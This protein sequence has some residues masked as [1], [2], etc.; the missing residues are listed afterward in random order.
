[1]RD[2]LDYIIGSLNTNTKDYNVMLTISV[3]RN[4][5]PDSDDNEPEKVYSYE[6]DSDIPDITYY[7][8]ENVTI[9]YKFDISENNNSITQILINSLN[10]KSAFDDEDK[11]NSI[12]I[13]GVEI[14]ELSTYTSDKVNHYTGE[15][16]ITPDVN[17]TTNTI[18]LKGNS[19]GLPASKDYMSTIKCYTKLYYWANFKD[20]QN[21]E[22]ISLEDIFVYTQYHASGEDG[23]LAQYLD[24]NDNQHKLSD[25]PSIDIQ[26]KTVE[27]TELTIGGINSANEAYIYIMV[28]ANI[29]E[30]NIKIGV[31]NQLYNGGFDLLYEDEEFSITEFD[32]PITY[33]LYRT[34]NMMSG[35]VNIQID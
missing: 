12:N 16:T 4:Y 6:K 30:T 18:T 35:Q 8:G 31:G 20:Q 9:Q 17:N 3:Y 25:L 23:N 28:P 1:L 5:D 24:N 2:A 21:T 13:S 32:N 34:S 27:K 10:I 11:I 19:A 26:G 22:N 7:N 15:Y 29:L 14:T 33:K